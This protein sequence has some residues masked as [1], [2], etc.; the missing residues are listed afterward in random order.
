MDREISKD[1][2]KKE[3]RKQIIKIGGIA[4]GVIALIFILLSFMQTTLSR[5]NLTLSAVDQG[6]IEVSVN[7]SGKVIPAFEE[8]VNSPINSR[9]IEIYRKGE[10]IRSMWEHQS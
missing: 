7:A 3:Q 5:N 10:G 8:I 6:M 1:V 2:I 4:A 9:I